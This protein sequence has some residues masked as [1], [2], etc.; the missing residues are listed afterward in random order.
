MALNADGLCRQFGHRVG[1]G[2]YSR[3]FE[4]ASESYRSA[5][6]PM[7]DTIGWLAHFVAGLTVR[8]MRVPSISKGKMVD[9]LFLGL[10]PRTR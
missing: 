10:E 9:A 2:S 1:L 3:Y 5:I 6:R 4:L 8:S 7:T